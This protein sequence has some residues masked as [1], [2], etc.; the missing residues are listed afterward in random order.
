MEWTSQRVAESRTAAEQRLRN[1]LPSRRKR[2]SKKTHLTKEI[3]RER[4][5]S[6][7]DKKRDSVAAQTMLFKPSRTNLFTSEFEG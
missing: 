1:S 3:T 4:N 7:L 6:H 2:A 5:V